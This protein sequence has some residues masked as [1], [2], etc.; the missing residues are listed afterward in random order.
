MTYWTLNFTNK[1][2]VYCCHL[3]AVKISIVTVQVVMEFR[4]VEMSRVDCS[5]VELGGTRFP[6]QSFIVG[7]IGILPLELELEMK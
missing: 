4:G 1:F 6:L 5:N 7:T 2:C 3:K